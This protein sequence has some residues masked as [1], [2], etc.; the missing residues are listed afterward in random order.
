MRCAW[1]RG[2]VCRTTNTRTHILVYNGS[3][4]ILIWV[5][6]WEYCNCA[7]R[8]VIVMA[9][10]TTLAGCSSSRLSHARVSRI[11]FVHTLCSLVLLIS[12]YIFAKKKELFLLKQFLCVKCNF[13]SEARLL[14]CA[15]T[16]EIWI[17]VHILAFIYFCRSSTLYFLL[18]T[19][20]LMCFNLPVC[21][22]TTICCNFWAMLPARHCV[23][24]ATFGRKWQL[25][26]HLN[27]CQ[28]LNY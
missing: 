19:I 14:F 15:D 22:R 4:L 2:V 27:A 17:L 7:M 24:S 5:S 18:L 21:S 23:T 6:T 1:L 9:I 28:Y 11:K 8:A 10:T 3:V 25:E 16:L 26:A 12:L 13:W 20:M